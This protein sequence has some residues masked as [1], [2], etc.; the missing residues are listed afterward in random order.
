MGETCVPNNPQRVVTLMQY[1]LSHTLNLDVKPIGSNACSIEQSSA[2]Y[3]DVQS[4]PENN[5][6]GIVLLGIG[7]SPNLERIL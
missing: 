2:N 6:E 7:E 1:I 3:P 5:T 4:Y